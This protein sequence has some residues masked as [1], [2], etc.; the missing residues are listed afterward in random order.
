MTVYYDNQEVP[1]YPGSEYP[2]ATE[3]Q[4]P[5]YY[6][7]PVMMPPAAMYGAQHLPSYE[8][9]FGNGTEQYV[10]GSAASMAAA[11]WYGNSSKNSSSRTTPRNSNRNLTGNFKTHHMHQS[12]KKGDFSAAAT[13]EKRSQPIDKEAFEKQ[14]QMQKSLFSERTENSIEVPADKSSSSNY[15]TPMNSANASEFSHQKEKT[16]SP[17]A[18]NTVRGTKFVPLHSVQKEENISTSVSRT[19]SPR[20]VQNSPKKQ[21]SDLRAEF[22]SKQ[23]SGTNWNV[24]SMNKNSSFGG[25]GHNASSTYFNPR[26]NMNLSGTNTP[27]RSRNYSD[28][29]NASYNSNYSARDNTWMNGMNQFSNANSPRNNYNHVPAVPNSYTAP[30]V[31]LSKLPPGLENEVSELALNQSI[32]QARAAALVMANDPFGNRSKM[33]PLR[34]RE[35]QIRHEQALE[36]KAVDR[37]R[38]WIEH[39][40]R[41][42][43]SIPDIE[44]L[45]LEDLKHVP[46]S[47]EDIQALRD[48]LRGDKK[49]GEDDNENGEDNENGDATPKYENEEENNDENNEKAENNSDDDY[50][51]PTKGKR[52]RIW[53]KIRKMILCHERQKKLICEMS[54]TVYIPPEPKT[55]AEKKRAA[56]AAAKAA[57][58]AAE[59]VAAAEAATK[60]VQGFDQELAEELSN[61]FKGQNKGSPKQPSN[62]P[63]MFEPLPASNLNSDATVIELPQQSDDEN[64]DDNSASTCIEENSKVFK[65][66]LFKSSF[67]NENQQFNSAVGNFEF[68]STPQAFS[69]PDASKANFEQDLAEELTE[70][71]VEESKVEKKSVVQNVAMQLPIGKT[72]KAV[73]SK[74]SIATTA[75]VFTP[76]NADRRYVGNRSADFSDFSSM[77]YANNSAGSMGSW[78]AGYPWSP[79]ASQGSE[80]YAAYAKHMQAMRSSTGEVA[81]N[82]ADEV[83]YDDDEIEEMQ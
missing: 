34:K 82:K 61:S 49:D 83:V 51:K 2:E 27:A 38:R 57:R 53:K 63:V 60:M 81:F 40:K 78:S 16:V 64:K 20:N 4:Q 79:M 25:H 29:S 52:N 72:S 48:S 50:D 44:K 9:Y 10:D 75:G 59:A 43:F 17:V 28:F 41:G 58:E 15:T 33:I 77:R 47:A 73:S 42:G 39:L 18:S 6:M 36:A 30:P 56:E 24:G 1:Y 12:A 31:V 7:V 45:S 76:S 71:A 26:N 68:E 65:S 70:V 80:G 46:C 66:R 37:E 23:N 14:K 21:V 19:N 69:T 5:A 74:N 11:N 67:D 54:G 8:Q 35:G 32:H 3:S 22:F 13:F 55:T 62:I